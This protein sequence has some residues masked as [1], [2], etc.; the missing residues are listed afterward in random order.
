M[1]D[2][3]N[4]TEAVKA[5]KKVAAVVSTLLSQRTELQE[6]RKA[7]EEE[8]ARLRAEPVSN[9]DAKQ[10][11]FDLIDKGAEE[12][13]E[14]SN[15]ES[16]FHAI[17]FPCSQDQEMK[18]V[19][20][21]VGLIP[22]SM[23]AIDEAMA[24]SSEK[25]GGMLRNANLR[26]FLDDRLSASSTLRAYFFFGDLIKAKVE[27]YFDKFYPVY[28]AGGPNP[29]DPLI[30]RRARVIELGK[31]IAAIDKSIEEIQRQLAELGYKK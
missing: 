30:K 19:A 28:N 22:L 16:I 29:T 18:F 20:G 21:R 17:A 14:K 23:S 24:G 25:A 15:W 11:I 26:L 31:G 1:T 4:I 9:E 13:L 12:F 8:V 6:Q 7:F 3:L 5:A 10:F 27:Q 2:A